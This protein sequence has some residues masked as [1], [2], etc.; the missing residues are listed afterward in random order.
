[1]SIR[2]PDLEKIYSL[3]S[4]F[5]GNIIASGNRLAGLPKPAAFY[6]LNY[7]GNY[8]FRYYYS[9]LLGTPLRILLA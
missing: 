4:S 8:F 5:G 9:L 6:W 2:H 1:M 7:F 3:F